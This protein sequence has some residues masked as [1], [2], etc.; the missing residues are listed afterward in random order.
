MLF[1]LLFAS[2]R[3]KETTSETNVR[4]RTRRKER[5]S[6]RTEKE[7][8]RK[9]RERERE[10]GRKSGKEQGLLIF[11]PHCK[12]DTGGKKALESKLKREF[13]FSLPTS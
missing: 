10:R 1:P 3:K 7:K 4:E 8:E 11:C 12:F 13:F 9:K 5:E 2:S 6:E